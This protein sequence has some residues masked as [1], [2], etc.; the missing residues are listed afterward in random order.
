[1]V[2]LGGFRVQLSFKRAAPG[3]PKQPFGKLKAVLLH[4]QSSPFTSQQDSFEFVK[5]Q[6]CSDKSV[7]QT[8]SGRFIG[9]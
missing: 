9:A 2:M 3:F 4:D 5:A 6:L 8:V 7:K 1:M